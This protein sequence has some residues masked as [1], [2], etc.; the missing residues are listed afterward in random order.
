MS[1]QHCKNY[2]IKWETVHCYPQ[3]VDR[4]C[5]RSKVAWCCHWNLSAFFKICFH[6][7][8][9]YNKSLNDWSFGEK[10]I[11]FPSNPTVPPCDQS[12]CFNYFVTS[13]A[14]GNINQIPRNDWLPQQASQGYL[15]H[16][17]LPSIS[18]KK[19]CSFCHMINPFLTKLMFSMAG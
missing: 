3:N 11:L 6:F 14:T 13:C 12:F 16:P 4:C 17:G 9:L 15:A 8:L 7:V 18:C 5:M 19:V 2:D 1:G 10:W